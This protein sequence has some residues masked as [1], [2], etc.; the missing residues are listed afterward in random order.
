[1]ELSEK[2][3]RDYE[4]RKRM[5]KL[6]GLKENTESI[7]PEIKDQ[8]DQLADNIKYIADEIRKRNK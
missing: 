5:R 2:A 1:M 3:A 8:I 6:A 7:R 4:E